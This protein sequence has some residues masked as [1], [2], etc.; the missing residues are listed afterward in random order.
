[1]NCG[2][3]ASIALAKPSS[4]SSEFVS[5]GIRYTADRANDGKRNTVPFDA[6]YLS[7]TNGQPTII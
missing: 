6:P 7:Q 5:N 2:S 1:M 4:Q 3:T